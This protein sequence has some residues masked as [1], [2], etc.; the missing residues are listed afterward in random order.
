VAGVTAVA[1]ERIV[2]IA[3]H[4]ARACG[5]MGVM[6]SVTSKTISTLAQVLVFEVAIVTVMASQTGLWHRFTEQ[7]YS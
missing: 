4:H 6:T 5:D 1:G 7:F 2:L 3:L